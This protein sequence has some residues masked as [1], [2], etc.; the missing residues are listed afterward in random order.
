MEEFTTAQF[1]EMPRPTMAS[2]ITNSIEMLTKNKIIKIDGNEI[3]QIEDFVSWL[4]DTLIM[5]DTE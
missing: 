1:N 2:T 5:N 4:L 3:N